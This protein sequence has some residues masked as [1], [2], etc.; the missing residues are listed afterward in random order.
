MDDKINVQ[1]ILDRIFS[2]GGKRNQKNCDTPVRFIKVDDH[3]WMFECS[4]E[5]DELFDHFLELQ[6]KNLPYSKLQ[7][8]LISII[9]KMPE[10]FDASHEL[11]MIYLY[12]N[13]R[14]E[15]REVYERALSVARQY[16]PKKFVS[17]RDMIPWG[18][19]QNRPYLRLL[20]EYADFISEAEGARAGVVLYNELLSLNP[21]DNQGIR[22]VIATLYLKLGQPEKVIELAS[23]YPDDIMPETSVGLILALYQIGDKDEAQ[24]RIEKHADFQKCVFAEILKVTHK[25][26]QEMRDD[27]YI[28]VG[29]KDQAWHYWQEQG[30]CWMGTRGAREFLKECLAK[31]HLRQMRMNKTL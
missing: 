29:G 27:G 16:I 19:V 23:R 15:A 14:K 31:E 28:T 22:M 18:F 8:E 5:Y 10:V 6:D 7:K 30:S 20:E 1:L 13:R 26:P 4:V 21:G 9:D 12:T 17:G 11:A 2:F 25:K 3:E 24:K